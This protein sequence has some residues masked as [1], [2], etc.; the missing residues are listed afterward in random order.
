MIWL[1]IG[2]FF[3]AGCWWSKYTSCS[4]GS[5]QE[6]HVNFWQ[7]KPQAC[8]KATIKYSS[9]SPVHIP[10]RRIVSKPKESNGGV[11]AAKASQD[12]SSIQKMIYIKYWECIKCCIML[13]LSSISG[14]CGPNSY[15]W[16]CDT[17][18]DVPMAH[19]NPD[20][21]CLE[22]DMSRWFRGGGPGW[23]SFEIQDGQW[24]FHQCPEE[25]EP[26]QSI[27][28]VPKFQ[29]SNPS[30]AS[31]TLQHGQRDLESLQLS[32]RNNMECRQETNSGG[33]VKQSSCWICVPRVY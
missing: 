9:G 19:N 22:R 25:T 23:A 10:S 3:V 11:A 24:F 26:F 29:M 33:I 28:S 32:K 16:C 12:S 6:L 7:V 31:S 5:V 1:N 13:D 21:S 17:S 18:S 30:V 4:A 14:G 27:W 2:E 15:S 20:S 8:A